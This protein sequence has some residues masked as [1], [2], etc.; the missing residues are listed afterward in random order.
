MSDPWAATRWVL[1]GMAR[2]ARGEKLAN[3]VDMT[4]GY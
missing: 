2:H 4:L 1:D 3:V